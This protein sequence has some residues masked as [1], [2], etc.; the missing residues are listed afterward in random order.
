MIKRRETWR[1]L[2]TYSEQLHTAV[3]ATIYTHLLTDFLSYG[4]ESGHSVHFFA[5]HHMRDVM[6]RVH[7]Y[8][9]LPKNKLVHK[10]LLQQWEVIGHILTLSCP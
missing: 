7:Q 6:R 10:V 4:R 5:I 2:T 9:G 3:A 8:H 1:G